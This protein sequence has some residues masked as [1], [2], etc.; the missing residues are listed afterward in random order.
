MTRRAIALLLGA[1][2]LL[3]SVIAADAQ[4]G[5]FGQNKIQ[6][7]DFDWHVLEGEHVDVYY[8]PAEEWIARVALAYAE[9]SYRHPSGGSSTAFPAASRSSFTRRTPTSR[10]RTCSRSCRRKAC[11]A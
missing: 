4:I 2:L 10:R 3:A 11:S 5:S 6:Y 9:E 7:R 1:A 8:Y